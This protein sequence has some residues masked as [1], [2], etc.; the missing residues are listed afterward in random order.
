MRK[1]T[2][3]LLKSSLFFLAS[4]T[5][6]QENIEAT[7]TPLLQEILD[8]QHHRDIIREDFSMTLEDFGRGNVS[9]KRLKK[10]KKGWQLK[11]NKLASHVNEL[12]SE[13]Y[14][15]GCL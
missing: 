7:C 15:K 3:I 6:K 2:C 9:V 14:D 11:E 13:A 4:C 8:T 5:V 1:T 12:Y 10:E